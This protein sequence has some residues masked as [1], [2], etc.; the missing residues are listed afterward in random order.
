MTP[1][2]K[3]LQLMADMG[4]A[5]VS[6]MSGPSMPSDSTIIGAL[7]STAEAFEEYTSAMAE[8]V[9]EMANALLDSVKSAIQSAI[10]QDPPEVPSP[11]DI[12]S[13]I[14]STI[15]NAAP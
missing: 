15:R 2:Q 4:T 12:S 3:G 6:S 1:E 8:K 11:T 13:A 7:K 14:E 9:T 10:S 5:V